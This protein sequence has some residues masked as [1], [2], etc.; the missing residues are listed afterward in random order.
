MKCAAKS[1][2]DGTGVLAMRVNISSTANRLLAPSTVN[3]SGRC[4]L[5]TSPLKV[6]VLP[7]RASDPIPE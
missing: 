6:V 2:K 1:V 7:S 4:Q 3:N 5:I